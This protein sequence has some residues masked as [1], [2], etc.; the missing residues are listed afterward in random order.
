MLERGGSLRWS[1]RPI[2]RGP[3]P[4]RRMMRIAS[5]RGSRETGSGPEHG[6]LHGSLLGRR[7]RIPL[8]DHGALGLPQISDGRP[9]G[10]WRGAASKCALPAGQSN[11]Q[12]PLEI[13]RAVTTVQV[14]NRVKPEPKARPTG[15]G[16]D[17][18]LGDVVQGSPLQACDLVP[19]PVDPG[20]FAQ[21]EPR[22]RY[23]RRGPVRLRDRAFLDVV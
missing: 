19:L 11:E 21:N 16:R 3:I 4:R 18:E 9:R 23:R 10:Q 13:I 8:H 15:A 6:K 7:Q 12:R 2:L 5:P 20:A 1:T 17:A 14:I 22:R